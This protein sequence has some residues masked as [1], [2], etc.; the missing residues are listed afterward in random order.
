MENTTE[1]SEASAEQSGADTTIN[2]NLSVDDLAA[3]FV[4]KSRLKRK[5]HSPLLRQLRM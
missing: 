4:E 5:N 3:S 1:T 2:A